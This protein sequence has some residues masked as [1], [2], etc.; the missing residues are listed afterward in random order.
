M[1]KSV[2]LSI[3]LILVTLI[4]VILTN[5]CTSLFTPLI[6]IEIMQMLNKL[7]EANVEGNVDQIVIHYTDPYSQVNHL[8]SEDVYVISLEE[9]RMGLEEDLTYYNCLIDDFSN[10]EIT[11]LDTS[12][13]I[14]ECDEH[15]KFQDLLDETIYESIDRVKITLI[16]VDGNWKISIYELLASEEVI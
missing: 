2:L 8:V 15:A 6:K 4:F 16:K 13:A 5:G 11:I 10:E 12:N 3:S 9:L 7:G 1:K 14:V